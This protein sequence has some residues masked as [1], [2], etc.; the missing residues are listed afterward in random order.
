MNVCLKKK[1]R[2]DSTLF[3]T[4]GL[5]TKKPG[6]IIWDQMH[7]GGQDNRSA[8]NLREM[9]IEPILDLLFLHPF[10]SR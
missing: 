6:L 9:L 1:Y 8:F 7:H 10:Y 2:I 3:C 5:K 4:C